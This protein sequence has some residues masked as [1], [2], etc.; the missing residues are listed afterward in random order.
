MVFLSLSPHHVHLFCFLKST[1]EW[2]HMVF[3]FSDWLIS[4]S[5]I[6][7][8]PSTSLQMARFHSFWWL[9]N[10]PLH[11]YKYKHTK[12]T[13]WAWLLPTNTHIQFLLVWHC[14]IMIFKIYFIHLF[15]VGR[16]RRERNRIPGRHCAVCQCRTPCGASTHEWWV[17]DLSRNHLTDWATQAPQLMHIW[18]LS[19]IWLLLM[20]L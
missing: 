7:F 15:C 18:A 10:I 8:P 5:I 14:L 4:L 6:H 20:L 16:S 19:I 3:V 12:L 13:N 9:S 11:I 17:H 1:Y 2:N